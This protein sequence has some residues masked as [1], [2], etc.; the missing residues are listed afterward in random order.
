MGDVVACEGKRSLGAVTWA[1]GTLYHPVAALAI[2]HIRGW[3]TLTL[4]GFL[5][6]FLLLSNLKFLP[7]FGL[8]LN[9]GITKK[10]QL[11]IM[12]ILAKYALLPPQFLNPTTITCLTRPL[13]RLGRLTFSFESRRQIDFCPLYYDR[14]EL[15]LPNFS[16]TLQLGATCIQIQNSREML[17]KNLEFTMLEITLISNYRKTPTSLFT[18][19]GASFLRFAWLPRNYDHT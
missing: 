19:D 1:A 6:D 13:N 9:F 4:A 16:C 18:S 3:T 5:L 11:Q 17:T 12:K 7:T 14:Y 10:V 2:W 15:F 8:L